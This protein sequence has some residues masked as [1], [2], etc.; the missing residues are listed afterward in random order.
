MWERVEAR[1]H[2]VE[3]VFSGGFS[4]PWQLGGGGGGG[5]VENLEFMVYG[6][7]V[8]TMKD[9]GEEERMDW[10]A[11]A[12]LVLKHPRDWMDREWEVDGDGGEASS[13][14]GNTSV[15]VFKGYRVY[16]SPSVEYSSG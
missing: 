16:L 9:T 3:K 10:A 5:S 13:E 11:H 12:E 1:K 15:Y 2:T 6:T 7:V 8:Y 14:R 4:L